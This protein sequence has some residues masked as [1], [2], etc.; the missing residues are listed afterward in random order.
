MILT[1]LLR[2]PWECL[3]HLWTS[4]IRQFSW[5]NWL[6]LMVHTRHFLHHLHSMT[7]KFSR[8]RRPGCPWYHSL[9][10][11][12][13]NFPMDSPLP[14]LLD[15]VFSLENQH[16]QLQSALY[17]CTFA[18]FCEPCKLQN[19]HET[20]WGRRRKSPKQS[21]NS[22]CNGLCV[23]ALS[24]LKHPKNLFLLNFCSSVSPLW[25]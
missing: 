21:S 24:C 11:A 12:T 19:C 2:Q 18:V 15:Q 17:V 25:P 3:W 10:L 23:C 6:I 9:F 22:I 7:A 16:V 4:K 1:E 8:L 20:S 13:W 14:N 5:Y